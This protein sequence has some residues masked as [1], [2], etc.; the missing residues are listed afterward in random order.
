M[1]CLLIL[2]KTIVKEKYIESS[3]HVNALNRMQKVLRWL[4]KI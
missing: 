3:W 2:G 1:S 4:Q